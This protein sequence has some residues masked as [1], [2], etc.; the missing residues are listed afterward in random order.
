MYFPCNQWLAR[1]MGDCQT[2][3]TLQATSADPHDAL[4]AYT[5]DIVTSDVKGAGTTAGVALRLHGD[6]EVSG[7]QHLKVHTDAQAGTCHCHGWLGCN[8]VRQ[9]QSSCL[10]LHRTCH[11]QH[12]CAAPFAPLLRAL[13]CMPITASCPI[14]FTLLAGVQRLPTRRNRYPQA[15]LP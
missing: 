15:F 2:V 9:L 3:R 1:D 10:H 12:S 6:L 14:C 8:H 7:I 5:V 11:V 4:K 13:G